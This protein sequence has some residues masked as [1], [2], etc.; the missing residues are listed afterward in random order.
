MHVAILGCRGIPNH[1]GGFEQFAQHL[2]VWLVQ[3]GHRVTVYNSS[4]HPY[5]EKSYQG[6]EIIHC[7]DPENHWGTAGQFVYD[8]GCILDARSRSYEVILQLGYTSSAVWFH[9]HPR[10]VPVLTNMDGLE[11]KRSKYGSLVRQ[12]LRWSEARAARLSHALIADSMAIQDYLHQTYGKASTFIAYSAI[13]HDAYP[14]TEVSGVLTP[15]GLTSGAYHL[16]IARM[17]PDNHIHTILEGHAQAC[18]QS[19]STS[20]LVLVGNPGNRFAQDLL[21][22][23]PTESGRIW[24]GGLYDQK[25][26][27]ILRQNCRFYFHGHSVG[28]TNPSLLEA[29]GSGCRIIAHDNPFNRSVLEE[30]AQY[31]GN[32][33]QVTE[34]LISDTLFTEQQLTNNRFKINSHYT[35][36]GIAHAYQSLL[37]QWAKSSANR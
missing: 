30:D 16:L 10:G 8:L 3:Q 7:Y 37:E 33:D 18:K 22:R 11:W 20:P 28:G 23:Y 2:A 24:A 6:V 29:M 35:P 25:T 13:V 9:W 19:A 21:M 31:F 4:L 32:S 36:H 34:H 12:F 17:E 1:Y 5:Q 14:E 15:Y 26:I 27:E